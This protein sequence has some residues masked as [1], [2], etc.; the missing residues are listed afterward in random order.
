M[1]GAG[2]GRGGMESRRSRI[3]LSTREME[4]YWDEAVSLKILKF[5]SLH[6]TY[7]MTC[8][9]SFRTDDGP[10]EECHSAWLSRV[11]HTRIDTG[12][13]ATYNA[14]KWV[15]IATAYGHWKNRWA[16]DST[17]YVHKTQF[18]GTD[19]PHEERR[20]L[21]GSRPRIANQAM[22]EHLGISSLNQTSLCQETVGAATRILFQIALLENV[23]T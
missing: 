2:G 5:L 23:G 17:P 21:V 1:E 3:I 22:K 6:K 18:T 8:K 15:Q 20:S 7:V 11:E 19:K 12:G 10:G 13:A 9:R 14:Q 16:W 4:A